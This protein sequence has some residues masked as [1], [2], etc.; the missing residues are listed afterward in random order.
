MLKYFNAKR[1][2]GMAVLGTIMIVVLF[3]VTVPFLQ[4]FSYRVE[5]LDAQDATDSL[6]DATAY[7][8]ASTS[9]NDKS[10]AK[11]RIAKLKKII[12]EKTN[13]NLQDVD[14]DESELSNN[15]VKVSTKSKIKY[16]NSE[17][18][19]ISR[20]ASTKYQL[21]CDSAMAFTDNPVDP[22]S[23]VITGNSE[24][25]KAIVE[26]GKEKLNCPYSWG[27]SGPDMFDCSGFVSWTLN[28]CGIKVGRQFARTFDHMG[29]EV[30]RQEIQAGDL[31]TFTKHG[32]SQA[33][34]VGIVINS[35]QYIGA[36]GGDSGT[37]GKDPNAFVK[38]SP[39]DGDHR[40]KHFRR[41][42]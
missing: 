32:S 22:A 31:V 13:V 37:H 24:K 12:S 29:K 40:I 20:N 15:V 9:S 35:K 23:L 8:M 27:A 16:G 19:I 3:S 18:S 6:S 33:S 26:K 21:A 14:I 25:G 2:N 4:L 39:I 5:A 11:E 17:T 7:Y 34:H 1:G 41:L 36:N 30:K 10:E 42:Y 28:H 38:V